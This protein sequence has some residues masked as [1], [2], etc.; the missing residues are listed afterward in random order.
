[1]VMLNDTRLWADTMSRYLDREDHAFAESAP[2]EGQKEQFRFVVILTDRIGDAFNSLYFLSNLRRLYPQSHVTYITRLFGDARF[3]R[4]IM[5]QYADEVLFVE[6]LSEEGFK[7]LSPDAIFD[8]NPIHDLFPYYPSDFAVRA[9]HHG[10]CDIVVPQPHYNWKANDHLNILRHFEKEVQYDYPPIRVP[11]RGD[12]RLLLQWPR[13]AYVAVCF[14]ATARS[15]MMP[16][17]VMDDVIEY[18]LDRGTWDIC[19]LGNNINEHGYS[20]PQSS[21][22]VHQCTGRLSLLQTIALLAH[23]KYVVSVDTG[24]MHIASYLGT[25][26]LG[27][28][29]CGYPGKNGPQGQGG[30][31]RVLRVRMDPPSGVIAKRDYLQSGRERRYLR[32][33][34]VVEGIE[35]LLLNQATGVAERMVPSFPAA[36]ES[37]NEGQ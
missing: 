29:T 31:S 12:R 5:G 33:D 20:C 28:F 13:G 1:M 17:G 32:I 23:A 22:R 11:R 8:L 35:Q 21:K 36:K 7:E 10:R 37:R 25:P 4:Q 16:E 26:V 3:G 14:E 30:V 2:W 24:L 15:W 9:G 27:V 18:L 19:I 6:T 34:H